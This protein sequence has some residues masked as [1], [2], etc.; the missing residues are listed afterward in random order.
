MHT[1]A[2]LI[3]AA[4]LM[5]PGIVA[6]ICMCFSGFLMFKGWNEENQKWQYAMYSG[7]LLL[8]AASILLL[9]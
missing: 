1:L 5:S 8:L 2:L 4:V 9:N 7:A 3:Y 6:I